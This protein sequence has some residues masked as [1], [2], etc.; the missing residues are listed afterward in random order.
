MP[1]SGRIG[2]PW[3]QAAIALARD[4]RSFGIYALEIAQDLLDGGVEAIDIETVEGSPPVLRPAGIVFAQPVHEL[5]NLLV[6]PHPWREPRKRGPFARLIFEMPH[7]VV[8]AGS[9][10]PVAFDGNEGKSL[11][12]DE[13]ARDALAH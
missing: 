5:A 12:L 11:F 4:L 2:L 3:R 9:V 1:I 10:R 8:D 7:I 6:A 13:L